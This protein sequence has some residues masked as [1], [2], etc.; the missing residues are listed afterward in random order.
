VWDQ[1]SLFIADFIQALGA[2]VNVKWVNEGKVFIGPY[3]TA[4]GLPQPLRNVQYAFL[5]LAT[6]G[7]IQQLGETVVAIT[8]LVRRFST[9]VGWT[10]GVA[11]PLQVIAIQTF[12]VIWWGTGKYQTVAV[13]T[14]VTATVWFF[15]IMFVSIS[16]GIHQ[17]RASLYNTPTPVSD[18]F[19]SMTRAHVSPKVLVLD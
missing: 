8:T 19:M 15:V 4:Q 3:C 7:V 6:L 18:A 1:L 12:W 16:A 9:P 2:V 17:N 11:I 5:W 13:A 14:Y 10:Q